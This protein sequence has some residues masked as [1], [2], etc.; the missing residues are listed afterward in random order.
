MVEKATLNL[1][2][3]RMRIIEGVDLK[4]GEQNNRGS[5]LARGHVL[6][7]SPMFVSM[8]LRGQ[9]TPRSLEWERYCTVRSPYLC[10]SC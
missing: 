2:H 8:L 3:H 6:D 5:N 9:Q 7:P 10:T 4:L 1:F